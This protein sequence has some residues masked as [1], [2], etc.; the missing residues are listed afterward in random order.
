MQL[1]YPGVEKPPQ[2]QGAGSIWPEATQLVG[3]DP[4][5]ALP[6]AGSISGPWLGRLQCDFRD[7]WVSARLKWPCPSRRSLGKLCK[8]K[9]GDP[10]PG[11]SGAM[12]GPFPATV[13]PPV[14]QTPGPAGAMTGKE[15]GPEGVVTV[16]GCLGGSHT[17]CF[18]PPHFQD[19]PTA[20]LKCT[21][22]KGRVLEWQDGH[23]SMSK[24]SLGL[25]FSKK[26][27]LVPENESE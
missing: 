22:Q 5:G 19:S 10:K 15:A 18:H 1:V 8:G 2:L 9:N 23:S 11:I 12:G 14:V 7:A 17:S 3:T 20:C 26:E 21:R 13:H 24:A 6:L 16:S 27:E 4:E 25:S